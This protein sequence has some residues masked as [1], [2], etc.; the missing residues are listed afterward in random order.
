MGKDVKGDVAQVYSTLP[1]FHQNCCIL[2]A[3][4]VLVVIGIVIVLV[5]TRDNR[6]DASN[7]NPSL[8]LDT[9]SLTGS[10]TLEKSTCTAMDLIEGNPQRTTFVGHFERMGMANKL[11]SMSNVIVFAP[12]NKAF[13]I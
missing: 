11:R 3:V 1:C 7:R 8:E 12:M 9:N 5:A 13:S 6:T 10:P 4:V 2:F